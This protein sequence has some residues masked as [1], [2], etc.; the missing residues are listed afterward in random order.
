MSPPARPT[1]NDP[2]AQEGAGTFEGVIAFLVLGQR[3]VQPLDGTLQIAPLGEEQPADSAASHRSPRSA[4]LPGTP[5]EGVE[6]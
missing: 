6:D 1:L 5:F 4:K 2:L 3:R